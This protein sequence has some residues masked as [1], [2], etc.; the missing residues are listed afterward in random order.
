ME[1][2]QKPI[3]LTPIFIWVLDAEKVL[4]YRNKLKLQN[5]ASSYKHAGFH[6]N[7]EQDRQ[8]KH[9]SRLEKSVKHWGLRWSEEETFVSGDQSRTLCQGQKG[10]RGKKRSS[11]KQRSEVDA[12]IPPT[13]DF[14]AQCTPIP[15]REK[16]DC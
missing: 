10:N 8:S 4:D 15:N 13:L 5:S 9:S 16:H 7:L 14:S 3:S 11:W 12:E 6:A 2:D 1:D